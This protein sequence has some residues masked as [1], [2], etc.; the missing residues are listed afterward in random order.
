MQALPQRQFKEPLQVLHIASEMM[1][2]FPSLP[3]ILIQLARSFR[4]L[5]AYVPSLVVRHIAAGQDP[6]LLQP[7]RVSVAMLA[8]DICCFTALSEGSSLRAVWQ[9]CNTFIESCIC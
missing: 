6:R 8:A 9:L 2:H 3:D 4:C 7:V 1:A 5:E